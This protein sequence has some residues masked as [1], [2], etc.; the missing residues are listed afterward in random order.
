MFCAKI[1]KEGV[2]FKICGDFAQGYY[3]TIL[4][5]YNKDLQRSYGSIHSGLRKDSAYRPSKTK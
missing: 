5:K 4:D 3:S 2:S 1:K